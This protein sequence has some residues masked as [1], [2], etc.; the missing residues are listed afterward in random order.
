MA[1]ST[2]YLAIRGAKYAEWIHDDLQRELLDWL[3]YLSWPIIGLLITF[4]AELIWLFTAPPIYFWKLCWHPDGRSILQ[5][6]QNP[7]FVTE[8]CEGKIYHRRRPLSRRERRRRVKRNALNCNSVFPSPEIRGYDAELCMFSYYQLDRQ[9]INKTR[10]D[11]TAEDGTSIDPL[12][13]TMALTLYFASTYLTA[14]DIIFPKRPRKPPDGRISESLAFLTI[15]T[16]IS[17]LAI[18]AGF[19]LLWFRA[20]FTKPRNRKIHRRSPASRARRKAA[21]TSRRRVRAFMHAFR[22]FRSSL[23][24]SEGADIFHDCRTSVSE[25][26]C[27]GEAFHDCQEFLPPNSH[28]SCDRCLQPSALNPMHAFTTSMAGTNDEGLNGQVHFDTDSIFFVC[29]NS[30]T[31]HICND[32]RKFI[33]G[34]LRQS[35]RRLT[36]AHGTG[37][38]KLQ[39]GTVRLRLIDDD[40][41]EHIFLL[42]NC[43]FLPESPVNLLSTRRLAE[44]FLDADGNPDE[45]TRIN[46]GYSTH[47][48]SWNFG[49][50]KKTFPTPISGLPELL[51]DKGFNKFQ[52]FCCAVGDHVHIIPDD[53]DHDDALFMM[54]ESITFQDGAGESDTVKYLGPMTREGMVKHKIKRSDDSEFLVD[55]EHLSSLSTPNISTVPVEIE[56]YAAELPN[57]SKEHLAQ[58]SNPQILD[59]DQRELIALHNKLNHL[60]FPSMIKLAEIGKI[61]KKLAKLKNRLPVCMS[62]VFG[63]A[64]KR[65]WRFK[66][67]KGS[68]SSKIRNDN[69]V[70]P[71][72]CVS[73]D[74]MVSA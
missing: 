10:C 34:T 8:K 59:D 66:G 52:S 5:M 43:I 35:G 15:V 14:I 29:D 2:F 50:Y 26:A 65:P 60:P 56:Q 64:H 3:S 63:R 46:S 32:F 4:G 18:Y 9:N 11:R 44:K 24:R 19:K 39:E 49:K 73:L 54:E 38:D 72:D 30:T 7:R 57:L 41:R 37:N 42:E 28:E 33:P 16:C 31:G 27:E 62:C 51:F 23:A 53:D 36:T 69:E 1:K 61:P 13:D 67:K 20:K 17:T 55:R 12:E 48:L 45:N 70:A 71:G 22:Q 40:D 58:I 21:Y 47:V 6:L 74:Q 68:T 25:G